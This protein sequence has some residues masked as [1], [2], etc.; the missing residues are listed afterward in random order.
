MSSGGKGQKNHKD[1]EQH[2]RDFS[3]IRSKGKKSR[4]VVEMH[5]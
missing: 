2:V 4:G 3:N 1:D 5:G